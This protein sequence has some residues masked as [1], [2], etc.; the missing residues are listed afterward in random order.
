MFVSYLEGFDLFMA[1]IACGI[2]LRDGFLCRTGIREVKNQRKKA[3]DRNEKHF[4]KHRST[5]FPNRKT[6]PLL[7]SQHY[8]IATMG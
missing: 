1:L 6:N 8:I 7:G 4:F 3:N 5:S 2:F